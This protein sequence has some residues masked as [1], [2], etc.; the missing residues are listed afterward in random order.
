MAGTRLAIQTMVIV[1]LSALVWF[2]VY[3]G[4]CRITCK[5]GNLSKDLPLVPGLD[6]MGTTPAGGLF[7][8]N[9]NGAAAVVRAHW[10]EN[11]LCHPIR[12]IAQDGFFTGEGYAFDGGIM[13]PPPPYTTVN[14]GIESYSASGDDD[15]DD[16]DQ[17]DNNDTDLEDLLSVVELKMTL[18][19][20][21]TTLLPQWIDLLS[22]D[23]QNNN[24]DVKSVSPSAFS[25]MLSLNPMD[26]E[27]L[28]PLSS[29]LEKDNPAAT[30][31]SHYRN[32]SHKA[33]SESS[34]FPPQERLIVYIP[35]SLGLPEGEETIDWKAFQSISGQEMTTATM[36]ATLVL[37]SV[38][39]EQGTV[40]SRL[41]L[42][43]FVEDWMARSISAQQ[44]Q[45]K[46]EK[47]STRHFNRHDDANQY[48]VPTT[49]P[50]T[51]AQS[52]PKTRLT[53]EFPI[54]HFMAVLMP[55]LFPL[56]LPFLVSWVKEYK[57]HKTLT[58]RRQKQRIC[59]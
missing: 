49:A 53:R 8:G 5:K 27:I 48:Y 43:S 42:Q 4:F 31:W 1:F 44:Q 47:H 33:R 52:R 16:Q 57:R 23:F 58:H 22:R 14:G 12:A 35:A 39:P 13:T 32:N 18:A 11:T 50:S 20:E 21:N 51:V 40:G 38:S 3:H 2:S 37:P 10:W 7:N 19:V 30:F 9:G 36:T 34:L 15:G 55:L 45:R 24:G 29:F 56:I 17:D 41:F 54:E 46:Q 28:P 59:S 26:L 25:T 6:E